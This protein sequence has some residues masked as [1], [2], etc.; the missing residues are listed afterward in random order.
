MVRRVMNH[1]VAEIAE[2]KAGE[3]AGRQSSEDAQKQEIKNR[4]HRYAER[5]RRD[6]PA[7][8]LRIIVVRAVH[9]K[10]D[11]FSQTAFR[12]VMK[13]AAMHQVFHQRSETD[14]SRTRT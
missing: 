11:S 12:F 2:E 6:Q 3:C 10:V 1:V 13:K 5:R 4:R 7:G 9:E 8:I 14:A